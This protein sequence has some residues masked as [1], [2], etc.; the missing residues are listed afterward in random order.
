MGVAGKL[1][2]IP[3]TAP[4]GPVRS[5]DEYAITLSSQFQ[6]EQ[7]I[8]TSKGSGNWVQGPPTIWE[9]FEVTMGQARTPALKITYVGNCVENCSKSTTKGAPYCK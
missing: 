1:T 2:A 6:G 8:E 5:S 7:M 3:C 4:G 9:G